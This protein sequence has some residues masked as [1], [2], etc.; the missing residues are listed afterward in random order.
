MELRVV[1]V[2]D[3]PWDDV[4]TVFGTRGNPSG[5]WCQYF[6]VDA[7]T[8]KTGDA[9]GFERALCDQVDA[10]RRSGGAGPGVLAYA[11]GEPVGWAAVEQR[12]AYRRLVDHGPTP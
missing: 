6:K 7:A 10:G 2:V 11:A 12:D 4:R 1:P 5:C 9:A 3:A 8:W